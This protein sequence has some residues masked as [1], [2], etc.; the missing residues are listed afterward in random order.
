MGAFCDPCG[1]AGPDP[2]PLEFY[3]PEPVQAALLGYDFGRFFRRVRGYKQWS[4]AT[5]GDVLDLTQGRISAIEGGAALYDIRII[6]RMHQRL[7]IP[8]PLL[9]F[10]DRATVVGGVAAGRK[11]SWMERR[12]F[13]QHIATLALGAAGT[14]GLDIDRLVALLYPDTD[15]T[16]TRRI[17]AADVAALEYA[18]AGYERSYAAFG[19]GVAREAAVTQLRTVLPMLNQPM[20]D[21]LAPRLHIAAAH[22]ALITAWTSFDMSH[23]DAARRFSTVGLEIAHSTEHPLATDLTSHLLF[24]LAQQA[25]DLRRPDEAERL[26][27]IGY[28]TGVGSPSVF[29]STSTCLATNAA[30]A[31]AA[32]GDRA[33]CERALGV[34][35]EAFTRIDPA[36]ATPWAC[37]DGPVKIAT[38]Q[39]HAYYELAR[40]SGDQRSVARA[41]QLLR[42]VVDNPRPMSRALYL[43]DL[44]GAHAL[45]GD[46]GTAVTLGHQAVDTVT[47][48]SSRRTYD[49]LR[50][51]NGVLEPMR[52]SPGVA[53]LRERLAL[54]A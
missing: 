30:F 14:T 28:T 19:G 4:Q 8:A 22:L 49:R 31:H 50:V 12:D 6:A 24:D 33:Q 29:P 34:A 15:A 9:G 53:E 54:A 51:L 38:W 32:R 43:P 46:I 21:D 48:M 1:R 11:G 10:G 18:T 44:V 26:V 7:G 39:G 16:G 3:R 13:V 37:V 41:V 27:Q 2:L 40:A 47:G 35:E 20:D 25:L 45:A 52:T 5:L 42:Q 23:H 36:A 17:G